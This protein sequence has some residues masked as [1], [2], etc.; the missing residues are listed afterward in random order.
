MKRPLPSAQNAEPRPVGSL[1]EAS[2][3]VQPLVKRHKIQSVDAPTSRLQQ[4]TAAPNS[5]SQP[6]RKSQAVEHRVLVS[7]PSSST[8]KNKEPTG[9]SKYVPSTSRD[10]T[11]TSK[12]VA[13][14]NKGITGTSNNVKGKGM[15]ERKDVNKGKEKEIIVDEHDGESRGYSDNS[16][17]WDNAEGTAESSGEENDEVD[18]ETESERKLEAKMVMAPSKSE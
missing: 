4:V 18:S 14:P 8:V 1:T 13:G 16:I 17:P 9:K 2:G 15:D 12:A 3:S 7:N 10:V 6:S 5:A 11:G